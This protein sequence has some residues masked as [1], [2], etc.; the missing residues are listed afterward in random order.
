M[1]FVNAI[2]LEER[3]LAEVKA[4]GRPSLLVVGHD[5]HAVD[6]SAFREKLGLK[7]Y[8]PKACEAKLRKRVDLDGTFESFPADSTVQLHTVAGSKTGDLGCCARS[9]PRPEPGAFFQPNAFTPKRTAN[10]AA[11]AA[12]AKRSGLSGSLPD[13]G[14]PNSAPPTAPRPT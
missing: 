5:Q 6:A 10:S 8:G 13:S 7:T 4:W 1:L 11:M 3:A 9:P 2:P 12:K 14:A